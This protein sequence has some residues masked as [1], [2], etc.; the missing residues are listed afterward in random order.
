MMVMA[1]VPPMVRRRLKGSMT[2]WM[3]ILPSSRGV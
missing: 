2:A 1:D 3:A